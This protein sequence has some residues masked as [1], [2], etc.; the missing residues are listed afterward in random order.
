MFAI[1]SAMKKFG[2]GDRQARVTVHVGMEELRRI[3][4]QFNEM[5]DALRRQRENQLA[6]LAGVSHDLRNPIG[7]LNMAVAFLSGDRP[8]PPEHQIRRMLQVIKRQIEFLNRM[9]GDLHDA[10]QIEA[11]Q[12]ALR[13][14]TCDA[15]ELSESVCQLFCSASDAHRLVLD[16]PPSPVPV[17]CDP[18]RLRQV[19]NNL[20]SN[21]IK[22][23]PRGGEI[24]LKL[25]KSAT[26]VIFEVSDPGIGIPKEEL[27]RIFEPFRRTKMSRQD[28]SGTG[29]GLHVSRRIVEAHHGRIEVES[30]VGKGTTLRV[31]LPEKA[32]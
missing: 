31:Y 16:A 9:V 6:F 13:L 24:S 30:E 20:V 14:E 2:S 3:A 23:S 1:L 19:L 22:Y 29:L 28:I 17:T 32:A 18:F 10:H 8:L 26:E 25:G 21:A 5:A 7:A 27:S 4:S 15:R 11:G 12:L